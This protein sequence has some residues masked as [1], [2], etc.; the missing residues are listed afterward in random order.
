[1][2]GLAWLNEVLI[3]TRHR[4]PTL[5]YMLPRLTGDKYLPLIDTSFGYHNLSVFKHL[6][7]WWSNLTTGCQPISQEGKSINRHATTKVKKEFWSFLGILNYLGRFSPM[8]ADVYGPLLKLTSVKAEQSW[9]KMYQNLW[10]KSKIIIKNGWNFM[11]PLDPYT[12][13]LMHL[14]Y[15]LCMPMD[16]CM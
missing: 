12:S 16:Y 3:R 7:L 4:G 10:N 5:N 13:E 8:T 9:N 2:S 11:M 15:V 1:M 6:F 14:V